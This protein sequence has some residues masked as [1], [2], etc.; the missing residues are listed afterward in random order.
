MNSH[1]PHH[2]SAGSGRRPHDC[3]IAMKFHPVD[4]TKIPVCPASKQSSTKPPFCGCPND[5]ETK[6]W[7]CCMPGV[8]ETR[9]LRQPVECVK[10]RCNY[11]IPSIPCYDPPRHVADRCDPLCF[12]WTVD[13]PGPNDSYGLNGL[14]WYDWQMERRF[15]NTPLLESKTFGYKPAHPGFNIKPPLA[16]T[17]IYVCTR[18]IECYARSENPCK[19]S[20]FATDINYFRDWRCCEM[21]PPQPWKPPYAHWATRVDV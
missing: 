13:E 15:S 19:T 16:N 8:I 6:C 12:E 14:N 2:Q 3:R 9:L 17:P 4:V 18:P 7:K 1:A 5:L 11:S 21:K 20:P 10:P